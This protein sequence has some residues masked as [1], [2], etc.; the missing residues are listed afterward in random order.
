MATPPSLGTTTNSNSNYPKFHDTFPEASWQFPRKNLAFQQGFGCPISHCF[1]GTSQFFVKKQL[2]SR[3]VGNLEKLARGIENVDFE[4]LA[5][6]IERLWRVFQ[7]LEKNVPLAKK[8]FICAIFANWAEKPR[9]RCSQPS[10]KKNWGLIFGLIKELL[11]IQNGYNSVGHTVCM[12][13][14]S[15]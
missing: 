12:K 2:N 4:K 7:K 15:K 6:G 9:S 3:E 14:I 8:I 1:D 5:R 11:K 10:R 13:Y